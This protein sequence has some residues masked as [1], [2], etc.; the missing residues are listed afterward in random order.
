L[1]CRVPFLWGSKLQLR[2]AA[3]PEEEQYNEQQMVESSEMLMDCRSCN[4]IQSLPRDC[5]GKDF[6]IEE[7]QYF[8]GNPNPEF[9]LS[10]V[11]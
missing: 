10:M 8:I 1:G 4:S 11:S 2:I 3:A 5:R 6:P 7:H 9:G